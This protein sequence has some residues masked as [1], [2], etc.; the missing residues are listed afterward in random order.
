MIIA[1]SASRAC[2]KLLAIV[3]DFFSVTNQAFACDTGKTVVYGTGIPATG[4]INTIA[5]TT[6]YTFSDDAKQCDASFYFIPVANPVAIRSSENLFI[7]TKTLRIY[8]FITMTL[9]VNLVFTQFTYAAVTG[10]GSLWTKVRQITLSTST[11]SAN[12]QV[13]VTLTTATFGANYTNKSKR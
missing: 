8:L 11:P 5:N 4:C 13:K 9:L 1:T 10:P 2:K 7:K 12:F 3:I 6:T